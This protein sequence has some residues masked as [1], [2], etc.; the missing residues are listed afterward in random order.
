MAT[1]ADEI[2]QP[3]EL[4]DKA[5][6][7]VLV[8]GS[9]LQVVLNECGLQRSAGLFLPCDQLPSVDA[10]G[11]GYIHRVSTRDSCQPINQ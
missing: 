10:L 9:F 5:V 7:V 4:D 8:E 11:R 3:R 2:I 1:G 6:P